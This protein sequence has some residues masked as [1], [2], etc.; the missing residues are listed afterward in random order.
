M[1][2]SRS[3]TGTLGANKKEL[4]N[5]RKTLE[6]GHNTILLDDD[7]DQKKAKIHK[8]ERKVTEAEKRF[9]HIVST[10]IM[11]NGDLKTHIINDYNSKLPKTKVGADRHDCIKETL[12]IPL[13]KEGAQKLIQN[14]LI[15]DMEEISDTNLAVKTFKISHKCTKY[16]D[17]DIGNIFSR[18]RLS[19][20]SKDYNIIHKNYKKECE[21]ISLGE[22]SLEEGEIEK[23]AL[24]YI[25]KK[26]GMSDVEM[27]KGIKAIE[28]KEIFT[29]IKNE[30]LKQ[31]IYY[32]GIEKD[33]YNIIL[34][35]VVDKSAIIQG[36][37]SYRIILE[38]QGVVEYE[39]CHAPRAFV[40][41]YISRMQAICKEGRLN[42]ELQGCDD[43]SL[44]RGGKASGFPHEITRN[45][46]RE[47]AMYSDNK[48]VGGMLRKA[49]P[50]NKSYRDELKER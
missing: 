24:H 2:Q 48:V 44:S 46:E 31:L 9:L 22:G 37:P 15:K 7:S 13:S 1:E 11:Q 33:D 30:A 17:R 27:D 34:S 18:S 38:E 3:F 28:M 50:Y 12:G 16:I 8:Q 19:L 26:Y 39:E 25:A 43:K 10:H 5:I 41:Q 4:E 36:V 35:G 47:L 21:K 32:Q 29:E 42:F 40:D 23:R 14:Y 6:M 49:F 20:D 45:E